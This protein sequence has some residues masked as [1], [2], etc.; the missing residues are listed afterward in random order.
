MPHVLVSGHSGHCADVLGHRVSYDVLGGGLCPYSMT[1]VLCIG[2]GVARRGSIS[3][4]GDPARL[5]KTGTRLTL[6]VN[7]EDSFRRL[8][9][10]VVLRHAIVRGE[11]AGVDAVYLQTHL[12]L[13][14]LLPDRV[15][16]VESPAGF[17]EATVS[18]FP[19][20]GTRNVCV[21]QNVREGGK[22]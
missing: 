3:A 10:L 2:G 13:V 22:I 21:E 9:V 7:S 19:V 1:P 12:H 6:T 8:E 16:D 20:S 17:Q 4:G 18:S 15:V 11:I 5:V 14:P